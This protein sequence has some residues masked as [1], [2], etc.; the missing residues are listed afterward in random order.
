MKKL[1]IVLL[2]LIFAKEVKSFEIYLT[3]SSFDSL[4]NWGNDNLQDIYKIILTSCDKI[5]GLE[6][7][8]KKNHPVGKYGIAGF[9]NEWKKPCQEFRAIKGKETTKVIQKIFEEYYNPW[10]VR[11]RNKEIAGLFTGYY[12][13]VLRYSKV[14]TDKYKYPAYTKP[15]NN[16]KYLSRREI[17]IEKKLE[18]KGLEVAWFEDIVDIFFA[19]IQGSTIVIDDLG[20]VGTLSFAGSNNKNYTSITKI[21][22]DYK[23]IKSP[24]LKTVTSWLRKNKEEAL[25]YMSMNERYIYFN[26]NSHS[27]I[28]G[29]TGIELTQ[30][31]S[32]AADL[33]YLP[34][35]GIVWA[36]STDPISKERYNKIM[37]IH[38][39]GKAIKG[40]VRADIYWG[41]GKKA[42]DKAKV[43]YQKGVYFLFIPKVS[44]SILE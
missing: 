35:A 6:G 23:L 29:S 27:R 17:D 33:D 22:L 3:P 36:L 16:L 20:E 11:D 24:G 44:R 40:P 30:E 37:F 14:K 25:N 38:D 19:Q 13:P 4:E 1:F 34:E 15:K 8:E 12:T 9:S 21:L 26:L 42:G 7:K 18:G 2:V 10:L 32:L 5:I 39:K 28:H 31:R 43:T 41:K